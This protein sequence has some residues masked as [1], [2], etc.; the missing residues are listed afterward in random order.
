MVEG[1]DRVESFLREELRQKVAGLGEPMGR[2]RFA[3]AVTGSQDGAHLGNE[4]ETDGARL[5]SARFP[6]AEQ[7]EN[8]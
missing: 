5:R 8:E 6:S 7:S 4:L 1:L 3:S 2:R